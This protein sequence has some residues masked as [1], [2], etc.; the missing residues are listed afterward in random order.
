MQS[1]GVANGR[2][3]VREKNKVTFDHFVRSQVAGGAQ[4]GE[5]VAQNWIFAVDTLHLVG[6]YHNPTTCKASASRTGR[7]P[8]GKTKTMFY[9]VGL[10]Q[11]V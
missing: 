8:F 7:K 2:E 6:S 1:I 9:H 3:A 5:N 10:S 4:D 11:D